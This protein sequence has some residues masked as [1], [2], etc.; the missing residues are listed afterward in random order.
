[1]AGKYKQ[2]AVRIFVSENS[3]HAPRLR[4]LE[5]K[6]DDVDLYNEGDHFFS[7]RLNPEQIARVR[8]YCRKH[9]LRCE[10][11]TKMVTSMRAKWTPY[12]EE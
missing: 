5:L 6:F 12:K 10:V 1:M 9:G 4:R 11:E 7:V 8:A 2:T 3:S